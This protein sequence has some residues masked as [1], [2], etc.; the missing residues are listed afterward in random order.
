VNSNEWKSKLA[1]HGNPPRPNAS[2]LNAVIALESAPEWKDVLFYNEFSGQVVKRQAPLPGI[3]PILA[4]WTDRDDLTATIWLQGNLINVGVQVA[5]EAVRTVA[6]EHI[7]NPLLDFLND[8]KWDG[9]KRIR[10]WLTFYMRVEDTEYTRWAGQSWLISA[11]ARAFQPGC[12]A[13]CCLVLEGPQG[14]GKSRA[15]QALAGRG[16]YTD[17]MGTELNTKESALL[18]VGTWIIEFSELESMNRAAVG[19]VKAFLAR[20]EDYYRPPYARH[21]VRIPRQCVFI[22]TTNDS[23]YLKDDSG[24][25]RFWPVR[26]HQID[27]DGIERDR[28]QLWAEAVKMFLE[29]VQWWLPDYME[30]EAAIEQ[31]KRYD[32][33]PWQGKIEAWLADK[34]DCSSDEILEFCLKKPVGEWGRAD[35]MAIGSCMRML[36]WISRKMSNGRKRWIRPPTP[37]TIHKVSSDT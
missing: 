18:C 37:I 17:A 21:A 10:D 14:C 27:V 12:K 35:Q 7:V 15:V 6:N 34:N 28:E 5:A 2:L 11:V 4:E 13:D 8:L 9:T 30:V 31:N 33:H 36:G 19:A 22:G 23:R 26:C 16:L 1:T 24:G 32:P 29:G 25:R 3:G 20:P